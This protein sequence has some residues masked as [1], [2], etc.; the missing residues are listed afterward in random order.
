MVQ[1]RFAVCCREPFQG[2]GETLQ[3]RGRRPLVQEK[4]GGP[5][6]V[7][8]AKVFLRQRAR[9]ERVEE[10]AIDPEIVRGSG[11][12]TMVTIYHRRLPTPCG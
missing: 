12:V 10:P 5:D 7:T 2:L 11:F 9:F 6:V 8:M 1:A 3:R 4:P